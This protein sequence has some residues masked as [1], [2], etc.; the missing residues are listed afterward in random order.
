MTPVSGHRSPVKDPLVFL[1]SLKGAGI[2]P[3]LGPVKRLLERLG[4]PQELYKCILVGGTNGKG[5]I[6]ATLAA[7]L[8]AAG[9]RV[10]LYASPH[11]IDFRE[12]IR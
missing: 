5:S 1:D 8:H 7:V 11:L 12:R 4:N 9:H 10:G 6:A 2:R 3:G